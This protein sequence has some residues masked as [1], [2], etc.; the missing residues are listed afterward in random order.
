ML[1]V[2][3]FENC[4]GRNRLQGISSVKKKKGLT[5]DYE[6]IA[7]RVYSHGEPPANPPQKMKESSCIEEKEFGGGSRVNKSL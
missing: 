6:R 3:K 5:K 1:H 2:N 7:V 4:F